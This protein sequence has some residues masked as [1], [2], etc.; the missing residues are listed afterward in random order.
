MLETVV[1]KK[2]FDFFGLHCQR[3]AVTVCPDTD[4]Q[5][6]APGKQPNFVAGN[7]FR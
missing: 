5:A 2:H 1:E 3:S 6:Q 7:F 4:G